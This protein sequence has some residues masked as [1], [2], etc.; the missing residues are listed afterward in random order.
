MR[1]SPARRSILGQIGRKVRLTDHVHELPRNS[2]QTH[3]ALRLAI[4]VCGA[5]AGFCVVLAMVTLVVAL[6]GTSASPATA[7]RSSPPAKVGSPAT[8]HGLAAPVSHRTRAVRQVVPD[9]IYIR[10]GTSAERISAIYQY[11]ADA[12]QLQFATPDAQ[13]A[14][15]FAVAP[16]VA[17]YHGTGPRKL[18]SFRIAA[19]G[20]W[21]IS[22]GFRCAS[23]R[24]RSFGVQET[25]GRSP[26]GL[27]VSAFGPSGR[28]LSWN[29]LDPGTH[30][31]SVSTGCS[32]V[33]RIVAP[34]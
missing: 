10:Y 5:G 29:T 18:H 12:E 21:G 20:E 28:G 16:V 6:N 33:V 7:R 27:T 34:S 24:P 13:L 32:W 30:E 26:N 14:G 23:R 1:H 17:V 22:W 15:K 4:A 9:T 8:P 25:G 19:P 11:V 3:R 31:L 2:P